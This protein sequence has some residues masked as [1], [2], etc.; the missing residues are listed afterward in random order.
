VFEVTLTDGTVERVEGAE[1]VVEEGRF[2][3]FVGPAGARRVDCWNTTLA[4]YRTQDIAA[5]RR[6][7]Y[8]LGERRS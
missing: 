5:I 3:T 2:T 7:R 6:V 1:S 4:C 8:L